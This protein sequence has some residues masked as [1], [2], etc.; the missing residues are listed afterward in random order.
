MRDVCALLLILGGFCSASALDQRKT[1]REYSRTLWTQ[2]NGLPQD[3]IR[4]I[5]QTTDG[6]LWL[7]TDE[8][9]TRFDGYDFTNFNTGNSSLPSNSVTALAAGGDGSLW[10]GTPS[11]VTRYKDQHFRN[12]SHADGLANDSVTFLFVDHA[13]A[14]WIVDGG[15]LSRFDGGKFAN[16]SNEHD[17]ALVVTEDRDNN[18]YVAG[19][20]SV[21]KFDNGKF[22]SVLIL[23][24]SK[25]SGPLQ[26]YVDH[27]DNLW[28][29]SRASLIERFSDGRTKEYLTKDV[30]SASFDLRTLLQDR[31]GNLLVG[32]DG[33]LA[34]L[35]GQQFERLTDIEGTDHIPIRSLF[36]DLEGNVWVGSGRGLIRLR[37]DIFTIFGSGERL[38]NDEINTVHQDRSGRVWIGFLDSG[39]M[40]FSGTMNQ[41]AAPQYWLPKSRVFSLRESRAGE[42]LVASN[43]GIMRLKDGHTQVFVPPLG[44][45]RVYDVLEASPGHLF[46]ALP[47]GLG[48]LLGDKFRTVIS[49]GPLQD[50]YFVNL[51]QAVDGSVWAGT[52]R[53]G[54]WHVDGAQIRHYT[55]A[56]GLG[57]DAIRSLYEDR[58]GT[59]W[60]G[61]AGGG[62]NAFRNGH[63]VTY[64]ARNGLSSDNIFNILDD[65]ESLWLTTP[66][67]ICRVLRKQLDDFAEHRITVLSPI[68]YGVADGLRSAQGPLDFSAGG[69]R[70]INRSLWFVTGRGIAVYNSR[71]AGKAEE[72]PP[73]I[74]ILQAEA[75][76]RDIDWANNP[77]V[78]PG[79]GRLQIRYMAIHL[80]GPDRVQYA[81]KLEGFDSDWVKGDTR[82]IVNYASLGPGHY[83]FRLRAQLPAGLSSDASFVFDILPHYYETAWFRLLCALMLVVAGGAAY[84]LR[85]RQVRL[86]F[87]MVL[88]ERAR[89]AREVHDTLT[90]GFAGLCSQLDAI[91]GCLPDDLEPAGSFVNLARRMARHSLTEARRSLTDL[92]AASLD[93]Q[94]L[95]AALE[96]GANDWAAGSGVD[97]EVDVSGDTRN[98]PEDIA[99]H[100]LRIAQEAVTNALK[101]SK[102]SKIDLK[103]YIEAKKLTLGIVDNGR[104]FFLND[105]F[106]SGNGHFGLIGM[107][108][109][110]ERLRGEFRLHSTIGSGT[111][112]E[113]TVPLP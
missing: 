100:V 14:V 37:D 68:N 33:G 57:G 94:S 103:L 1:L 30:V 74:H 47:T 4:T 78:P 16:F 27:A 8:G 13:G 70:H 101:H 12:Y 26:I 97:V 90:Q 23:S 104:G 111:H 110:A 2:E 50:D 77:Q 9:V 105:V 91:A 55:T 107:R 65:G 67:G 19:R 73:L 25:P 64:R 34:R 51:A 79:N 80:R 5:A 36:E 88:E 53:K 39:L 85:V 92:R 56:E 61:T 113:I 108:E 60:I 7:G 99:H 43:E 41:T 112:L 6:Y 40:L 15:I 20:H 98:L 52:Y 106:V 46:L 45:K 71:V 66:R 31:D 44:I 54:L 21:T 102:A 89:L 28:V 82:R 32:T 24:A 84:Q 86:R 49:G 109:R 11:G 3:R 29:L 72:I 38:P 76:S 48:E 59:L 42:L 17:I 35:D 10:I 63:F 75:D 83:R 69:N 81:Y 87:A 22:I 58:K 62:L 18:V 95:A 93:E 96:S